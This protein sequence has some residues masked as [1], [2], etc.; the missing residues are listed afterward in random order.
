MG[1]LPL[2]VVLPRRF[3]MASNSSTMLSSLSQMVLLWIDSQRR[4][5]YKGPNSKKLSSSLLFQEFRP[6]G[7]SKAA[8]FFRKPLLLY[9][10]VL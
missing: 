6:Q 10:L 5:G 4:L 8:L 2:E 3:L 7:L 9:A 1:N